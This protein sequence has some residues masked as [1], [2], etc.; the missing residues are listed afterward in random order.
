MRELLT[1]YRYVLAAALFAIA[2]VVSLSVARCTAIH[3]A[4]GRTR[5]VARASSSKKDGK[6]AKTSTGDEP[7]YEGDEKELWDE[8]T[9]GYWTEGDSS[10][11]FEG[12]SLVSR[13]G[14]GAT[15]TLRLT[16]ESVASNPAFTDEDSVSETDAV[17]KGG[18]GERHILRLFEISELSEDGSVSQVQK[19]ASDLFPSDGLYA[20]DGAAET[21]E[22]R[23]LS[24]L[25]G[26]L[27]K[28]S[29]K[30]EAAVRERC[31]A[32]IP[33]ATAATW[34]RDAYFDYEAGTCELTFTV[35]RPSSSGASAPRL[36]ATVDIS[37]GDT[38]VTQ[39]E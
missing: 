25:P 28:S 22:V 1:R 4:G 7:T 36:K 32:S 5:S 38:E 27:S 26:S 37:T 39:D 8:L 11:R 16:V 10:L 18:D 24:A 14:D 33:T 9:A 21:M 3:S 19:V 6:R 35:T 34:A 13:D 20:D 30:I 17:V 12:R 15:E 29:D 23:G 31:I 2:L